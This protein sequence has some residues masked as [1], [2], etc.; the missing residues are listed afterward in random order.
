M[1]DRP[2]LTRLPSASR[3]PRFTQCPG[4]EALPHLETESGRPAQI[5]TAVHAYLEAVGKGKSRDKALADVPDYAQKFC[6][7]L[8]LEELP[9]GVDSYAHELL[10]AWNP[11]TGEARMIHESKDRPEFGWVT[12][13]A[14]VVGLST[15]GSTVYIGDFKSGWMKLGSAGAHW[16]LK[17]LALIAARA[18]KRDH[19]VVE[20]I[21]VREDGN[22]F[23]SR[24]VF[25]AFDL[26]LIESEAKE[27]LARSDEAQQI[28][29]R[30]PLQLLE[31]LKPGI[32]CRYCPA[33]T[34]CPAQVNLIRAIV[35]DPSH[36]V[37][38]VTSN[39]TEENAHEAFVRWK[40]IKAA[41]DSIGKAIYAFAAECPIDLGN[42]QILAWT[43][44][45][46]EKLDGEI[47]YQWLKEQYG[48]E[49]A[50][51]AT[52]RSATKSA[53]I[54]VARK[55]RAKGTTIKDTTAT[56]LSEIRAKGGI[57]TS[58]SEG[59]KEISRS[60]LKGN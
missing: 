14:D 20:L 24:G 31:Y 33:F 38:S 45:T 58:I 10:L 48:Q 60:K 15:K 7:A 23:R 57:K 41:V 34:A 56:I 53:L 59:V 11:S 17:I 47:V 16:Q 50:D 21:W 39:L 3:W 26:D 52:K 46:T 18:L 32:H 44:T 19:V 12:G 55:K 42:G 43:E 27:A 13:I 22:N 2:K 5:G 36:A 28:G 6:E 54:N 29:L 9:L 4:S 35:G 37:S 25:D 40:T 49:T 8:P 51:E 1:S 30:Y